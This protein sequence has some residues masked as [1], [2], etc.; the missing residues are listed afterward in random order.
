MNMTNKI[1]LQIPWYL[2]HT[3]PEQER[4][5]VETALAQTSEPQADLITW[6]QVQSALQAQPQQNPP[7]VLKVQLMAAIQNQAR[8][9]KKLWDAVS[10]A[11]FVV[12]IFLLLWLI[13]QPG[14]MLAWAAGGQMSA[15]R[16]YRVEAD[17]TSYQ[18]VAEISAQAGLAQYTFV[19][20]WLLPWQQVR[21][22]VEGVNEEGEAFLS[23][24]VTGN[25]QAVL[26]G[27]LALLICSAVLARFILAGL[28]GFGTKPGSYRP[29]LMA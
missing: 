20:A 13:I 28:A 4:Q 8:P 11:A 24:A 7:Q 6:M 9:V 17:Q 21:Y 25:A 27:Q 29:L 12:S 23:E 1:W 2:N 19:D 18:L 3:L 22:L 15:F 14:M 5:Q 16:V 10:Y 26:P